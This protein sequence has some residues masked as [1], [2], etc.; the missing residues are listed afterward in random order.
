MQDAFKATVATECGQ[1]VAAADVTIVSYTW[2]ASR[3][4]GN[5]TGTGYLEVVFTV[6]FASADAA[7]AAQTSLTDSLSSGAF[8]TE[9]MSE[10]ASRGITVTI[11]VESYDVAVTV[12]S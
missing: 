8:A 5:D 11:T 9:L 6:A 10:A 12:N 1:G 3:R 7:N 2:V 4:T